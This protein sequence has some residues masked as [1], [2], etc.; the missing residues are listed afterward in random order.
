MVVL[1]STCKT[2][3]LVF[4]LKAASATALGNVGWCADGPWWDW[5]A[6]TNASREHIAVPERVPLWPVAGSALGSMLLR[7]FSRSRI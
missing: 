6:V 3:V 7:S 1:L 2:C 4:A 5:M